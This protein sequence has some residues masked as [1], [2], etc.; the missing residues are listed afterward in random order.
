M[1]G[2][3]CYFLTHRSAIDWTITKIIALKK[4]QLPHWRHVWCSLPVS[5]KQRALL[6]ILDLWERRRFTAEPDLCSCFCIDLTGRENVVYQ[7]LTSI[8][9]SGLS[10]RS[11]AETVLITPANTNTHTPNTGAVSRKWECRLH[12]N[13][14]SWE[15]LCVCVCVLRRL[16]M[17]AGVPE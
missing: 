2:G 11:K 1:C 14:Q 3:L 6:C 13:K 8:L 17:G 16:G 7:S 10:S 12:I 4:E 9:C 15:F 5:V